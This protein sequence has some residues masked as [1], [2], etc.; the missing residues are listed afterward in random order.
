[1]RV[2]IRFAAIAPLLAFAVVASGCGAQSDT[3]QATTDPSATVTVGES[4][5]STTTT[6]PL[7][8]TPRLK[9]DSHRDR[10]SGF[11]SSGVESEEGIVSL[12]IS[13]DGDIRVMEFARDDAFHVLYDAQALR[14]ESSSELGIVVNTGALPGGPDRPNPFLREQRYAQSVA[15]LAIERGDGEM[16]KGDTAVRV[17]TMLPQDPETGLTTIR[18]MVV[19]VGNGMVLRFVE[20]QPGMDPPVGM[21]SAARTKDISTSEFATTAAPTSELDLG[22]ELVD[23]IDEAATR[24]GFSVEIPDLPSGF[25]LV[26]VAFAPAPVSDVSGSKNV[27]ALVFRKAAWEIVVTYRD[28][29]TRGVWTDPYP[30]DGYG[31]HIERHGSFEVVTGGAVNHAWGVVGDRVVTIGGGVGVPDLVR[32]I[33]SLDEEPGA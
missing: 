7:P 13:D 22:F 20:Y 16:V 21:G 3:Q 11:V 31:T 8:M 25:D 26:Q 9:G 28:A 17:V 24:A 6:A 12:L 27:V 18:D 10:V 5:V 4:I 32:A 19:D 29:A 30:W 33:Q 1:M 2:S 14:L 23:S 15:A